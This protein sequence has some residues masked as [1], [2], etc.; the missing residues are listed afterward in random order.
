VERRDWELC[1]VVGGDIL[2]LMV[3]EKGKVLSWKQKLRM[4]RCC[5]AAASSR[6]RAHPAIAA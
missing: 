3:G 2:H 1:C 4:L 6:S 5:V